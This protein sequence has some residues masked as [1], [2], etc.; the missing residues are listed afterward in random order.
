MAHAAV[1]KARPQPRLHRGF[2]GQIQAECMKTGSLAQNSFQFDIFFV[3]LH[4][5][6]S[7]HSRDYLSLEPEL[8]VVPTGV[9]YSQARV[10][11]R[12]TSGR[13]LYLE[14]SP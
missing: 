12:P 14:A 9:R 11:I 8:E 3:S 10:Q 7:N 2:S 5:C 6:Q 4:G 1:R 13:I